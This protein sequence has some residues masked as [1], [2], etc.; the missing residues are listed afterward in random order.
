MGGQSLS[1]RHFLSL[2][3]PTTAARVRLITLIRPTEQQQQ[4]GTAPDRWPR[5]R[6]SVG[7][8][9]RDQL[10]EKLLTEHRERG[11]LSSTITHNPPEKPEFLTLYPNRQNR[12]NRPQCTERPHPVTFDSFGSGLGLQN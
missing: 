2:N 9:D 1:G 8:P 3:K 6:C 5:K 4:Q 7:G 12:Q 11:P 10:G